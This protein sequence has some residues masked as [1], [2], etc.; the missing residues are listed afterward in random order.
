MNL[1]INVEEGPCDRNKS[2]LV[3]R[4]REKRADG[5]NPEDR[6]ELFFKALVKRFG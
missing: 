1:S 6:E 3:A 4:Y 2:F 5:K